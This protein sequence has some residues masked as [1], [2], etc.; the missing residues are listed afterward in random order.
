MKVIICQSESSPEIVMISL[1][2]TTGGKSKHT[3]GSRNMEET[4]SFWGEFCKSL[5]TQNRTF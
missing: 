3:D 5:P 1:T 4:P 2:P